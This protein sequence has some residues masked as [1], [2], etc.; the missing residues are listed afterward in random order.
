M[1]IRMRLT[2]RRACAMRPRSD[3]GVRIQLS[4]GAYSFFFFFSIVY[5]RQMHSKRRS[6]KLARTFWLAIIREKL[7]TSM[8]FGVNKNRNMERE[9]H[10]CP[11][12]MYTQYSHSERRSA[13]YSSF[14]SLRNETILFNFFFLV[15]FAFPSEYF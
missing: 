8:F 9:R 1:I 5:S 10:F 7:R 6:L 11:M 15:L 14:D 2:R 13:E 12:K 4:F 3:D